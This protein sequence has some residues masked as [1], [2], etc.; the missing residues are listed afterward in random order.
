MPRLLLRLAAIIVALP[1]TQLAAGADQTR[2]DVLAIRD[3]TIG[4]G[5]RFKSG[6]WQPVRLAVVAG[7]GGAR[8]RL[9]LIGL[10]GDQVPVVYRDES[11]GRIDL[12]AEQE[13]TVHLY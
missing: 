2:S 3:A 12:N 5:G 4:F 9:E 1:W 7:A 6:F 13:T 8:G 10:D 11:V